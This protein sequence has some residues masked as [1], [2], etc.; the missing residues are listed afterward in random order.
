MNPN[1]IGAVGSCQG[2][3]RARTWA[4]GGEGVTATQTVVQRAQDL[5][6]VR[7]FKR[8]FTEYNISC[9]IV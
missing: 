2:K 9:K 8:T 6:T 7:L 4:K 3:R 5:G 1:S